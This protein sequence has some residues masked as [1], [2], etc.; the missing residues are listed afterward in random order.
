ML[1][2]SREMIEEIGKVAGHGRADSISERIAMLLP[3]DSGAN[4]AA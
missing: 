2:A 3:A 1:A 4:L